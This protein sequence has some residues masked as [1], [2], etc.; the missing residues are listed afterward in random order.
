MASSTE[1][2]LKVA[3]RVL[4]NLKGTVDLGVLYRKRGNGELIQYTGS[5]YVGDID[6]KKQ[7]VVILSTTEAEFVA[8]ASCACQGV[9]MRRVLKKLGYFQ[10]KC[11][12]ML[13]E[14]SSTSKLKASLQ[15]I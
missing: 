10:D 3:K 4:R 15:S 12:T 2:H 11:I 9:L 13:C 8:A 14:N 1:L 5:D 6:D 7:P